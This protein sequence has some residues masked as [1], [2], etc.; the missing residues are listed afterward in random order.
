MSEKHSVNLPISAGELNLLPNFQKKMGEGKL[1]MNTIFRWGLLGKIGVR[2]FR[3]W[4]GGVQFL[5]KDKL[6][7]EI[8]S[9]NIS[10]LSKTFSSVNLKD[11][12]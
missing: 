6:K 8:F 9:E 1:D 5:H 2:Y 11:G 4:V 10:L 3:I 12:D 7:S